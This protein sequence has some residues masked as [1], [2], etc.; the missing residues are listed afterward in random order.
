MNF[1]YFLG[2]VIAPN[3][4]F[5]T[6]LGDGAGGPSAATGPMR[7][8]DVSKARRHYVRPQPAFRTA[9]TILEA[10]G[11]VVLC[12]PDG[13][14][15]FAGAV[16]LLAE[17]GPESSPT[18]LSPALSFAELARQK[19]G[20]PGGYIVRDQLRV[21]EATA[22]QQFEVH[23]LQNA[24]IGRSRLVIT[25]NLGAR[26]RGQLGEL[27]VDWSAPEPGEILEEWL[28]DLPERSR[29]GAT[30]EKVRAHLADLASPADIVRILQA[31]IAGPEAALAGLQHADRDEVA[32]WFDR[33]P[34]VD[35]V[36]GVAALA[37]VE[38]TPEPTYEFLLDRLRVHYQEKIVPSPGSPTA[39]LPTIRESMPQ[40]RNHSGSIIAVG[41][42]RESDLEGDLTGRS[43][44]FVRPAMRELVLRQLHERY[45]Y[46]LWAPLRS[47]LDEVAS[48]PPSPL[49]VRLGLGVAIYSSLSFREVET[50]VLDP[51]ANGLAP[52]RL[53]AASALSWIGLTGHNAAQAL[54]ITKR[55]SQNSGPRRAV[56]A[57]S[58][59]GGPLGLRY[60]SDALRWLWTLAMR[61]ANIREVAAAALA[62]LFAT[63]VD[64]PDTTRKVLNFL[65][66]R[67]RRSLAVGQ[68]Q[69]ERRA[70]FDSVL[71][72]ISARENTSDELVAAV[73]LRSDGRNAAR[74]G[75]ILAELWCSGPHRAP[76]R[77]LLL[78]ALE[79]VSGGDE[80]PEPVVRLGQALSQVLSA[81]QLRDLGADLRDEAAWHGRDSVPIGAVL[82]AM[83]G[84][85]P[86]TSSV[87]GKAE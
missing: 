83:L 66:D 8:A 6:A 18:N 42:V 76:T 82:E 13:I 39:A 51:W 7:P 79:A 59:L 36:L 11:L 68:S 78:D 65:H 32:S 34:T 28:A 35:E 16:A 85:R 21:S 63:S 84:R 44:S 31:L 19:F 60:S 62:V 81:D 56:T 64:D 1:Q 70:T 46:E 30:F 67:L 2:T 53:A 40:T 9:K 43:I 17:T 26:P 69:R 75:P 54:G 45:G 24:V 61:A 27:M 15:K 71:T 25:T 10:N 14:G 38:G 73:I 57:A 87:R 12:G 55:W 50:M 49:H 3:G 80:I 29:S 47:W 33:E 86:T 37:F 22:V 58:A 77:S 48:R 41:S 72:T 52:Q 74:L 4:T 20:K 5:G 23:R